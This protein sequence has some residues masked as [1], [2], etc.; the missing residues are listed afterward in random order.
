MAAAATIDDL[1]GNPLTGGYTGGDE[2]TIDNDPPTPPVVDGNASPTNDATPTWTWT[3]GSGGSGSYR[4]G[5]SEGPWIAEDVTET[6]YTPAAPLTDG[7]YILYVQERDDVGN[8]STSGTYTAAVDLTAPT[9]SVDALTTNDDTPAVTGT[10]DDAAAMISV[11][12][13]S[14]TNP[15]TNNG[16]GTW[17]L[18]EDTL[19]TLV[20]GT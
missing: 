18:A 19:S 5:F 17:T 3:A 12:V 2:Y 10:V 14:Q 7:T 16:D 15:A 20:D 13:S 1:V 11:T 6:S 9:V 4:Y 8:W